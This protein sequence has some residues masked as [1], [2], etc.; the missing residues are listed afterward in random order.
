MYFMWVLKSVACPVYGFLVRENN[1]ERLRKHFMYQH[2]K[3]KV[4]II[5][6]GSEALPRC[7]HYGMN[8]TEAQLIKHRRMLIFNKLTD[9][10]LRWRGV[11][12][13]GGFR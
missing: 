11:E 3:A 10:Q 1:P 8:M 12:M 13:V 4:V 2:W 9:M 6:E 7:D 5:Q